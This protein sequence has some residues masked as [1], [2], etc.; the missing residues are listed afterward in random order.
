MDPALDAYLQQVAA[1]LAHALGPTLAGLDVHGSA[2]LG[3][4]SAE[5][6]AVD[7]FAAMV[8]DRFLEADR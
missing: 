5:R 4:R 2:A 6:S 8:L 7:R 1:G 3:G